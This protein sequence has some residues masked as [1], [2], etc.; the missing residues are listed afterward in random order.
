MGEASEH[1]LKLSIDAIE[2]SD[3]NRILKDLSKENFVAKVRD[4][5]KGAEKREKDD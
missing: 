1:L 2:E 5:G 4:L 3:E